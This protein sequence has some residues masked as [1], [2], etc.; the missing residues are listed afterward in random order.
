M[1]LTIE[2]L[3]ESI[4]LFCSNLQAANTTQSVFGRIVRSPDTPTK[5]AIDEGR[6]FV[7]VMDESG[8]K[9]M[10]ELD[11]DADAM[12]VAVGHTANYIAAQRKKGMQFYLAI[13]TCEEQSACYPAPAHWANVL[14][15]CQKDYPQ[16]ARDM[17]S[18][19]ADL[20]K[21]TFAQLEKECGFSLADVHSLGKEDHRYIDLERYL[22]SDRSTAM[23]R[24]FLYH[25]CRLTE[26]YSGDGWTYTV[27]G[28]ACLTEFVMPNLELTQL[29][30]LHLYHLQ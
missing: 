16:L 9:R 27:D 21:L 4:A 13:F 14:L 1:S 2:E 12:L 11:G 19:L 23:L 5:L 20:K 3:P 22:A 29:S 28:Q 7:M 18:A 17:D 6:K 30:D 25:C 10:D 24:R 15:E 8:L 26:L